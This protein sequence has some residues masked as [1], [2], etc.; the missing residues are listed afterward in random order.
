MLSLMKPRTRRLA[1]L[2]ALLAFSASLAEGALASACEPPVPGVSPEAGAAGTADGDHGHGST[3]SPADPAPSPADAAAPS[4]PLLAVSPGCVALA[5]PATAAEPWAS[6]PAD[7]TRADVSARGLV[8]L[9][10]PALLFHPPQ[11]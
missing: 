1:A 11:A 4:C 10:S 3:P 9:L 7:V 2:L 6:L 5:L 8:G